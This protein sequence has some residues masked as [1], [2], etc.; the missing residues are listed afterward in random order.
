[1]HRCGVSKTPFWCNKAVVSLSSTQGGAS[2]DKLCATSVHYVAARFHL[3]YVKQGIFGASCCYYP[4]SLIGAVIPERLQRCAS[5]ASSS[6]SEVCRLKSVALSPQG[7]SMSGAMAQSSPNNITWHEGCVELEKRESLLGQ[8]GC[9]VWITG[10][11]GSGK[12]T[13]ACAVEHCLMA[14]GKLSYVLDGDNIR[15]GLSKNLGFSAADREENIRRIGEVAKLFA[16]AGLITIVSFISP[17]KKD[18]AFARSLV[19]QGKF[20]EVYMKVPL[21][22][23]EKRDCKG[24]Y[25]LSRAGVLKGFTGVDDPYEVPENPEIE[26]EAT[27]AAGEF[28]SVDYMA[29]ILITYLEENGFLKGPY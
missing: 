16:D 24:L 18:R 2:R 25:K 20:L 3:Q 27:N 12:S 29:H 4:R 28:I 9:I 11:S 17:Y 26:I 22:V 21:D 10:L 15:H 6:A 7:V 1:M 13:L 5:Y 23:C 8:K 19:Q 14:K